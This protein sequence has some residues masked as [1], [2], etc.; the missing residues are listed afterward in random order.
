MSISS[1]SQLPS[2]TSSMQKALTNPAAPRDPD[3]DGDVDKAGRPD[4]EKSTLS[5]LLN[6]KA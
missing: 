2:N 3:H 5:G 1:I 4:I 6:I